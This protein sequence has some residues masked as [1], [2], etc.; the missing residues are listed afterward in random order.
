MSLVPCNV[1][2]HSTAVMMR[3]FNIEPKYVMHIGAHDGIEA[4][5][6]DLYEPEMVLWFECNKKVLP[7][8]QTRLEGRKNHRF[9]NMCLWDKAGKELEFFFYRNEKDGAS[10]LFDNEKM[11]DHIH[12]CPIVGSTKVK[13]ETF[14]NWADQYT[15]DNIELRWNRTEFLNIDVQGAELNVFKGAHSLLS[16][17]S[18]KHIWC[19]VSWDNV[20][21]DAPL[22]VDIDLYLNKYGFERIHIRQDW[23]IHGDA[24]YRRT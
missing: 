23:A 17:D 20:Y 6:Y 15:H 13:T 9:R 11:F 5:I 24:L 22:L 3:Q 18:L 4:D 8:L 2:T 1:F 7:G 16:L 19:E 21:K 12:D 10:G 14:D